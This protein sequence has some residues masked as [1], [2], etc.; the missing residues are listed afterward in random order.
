MTGLFDCERRSRINT[1]IR[2]TTV[3]DDTEDRVD[4]DPPSVSLTLGV[5]NVSGTV[6]AIKK[7]MSDLGGMMDQSTLSVQ[8]GD[9]SAFLSFRVDRDDFQ[10]ALKSIEGQG[11]VQLK[12]LQE[13]SEPPDGENRFPDEPNARIDVS[14]VEDTSSKTG[15]IVAIAAPSAVAFSVLLA[16]LFYLT[17]RAGG[18]RGVGNQ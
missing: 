10:F 11:S 5:S 4:S 6:D 9:D 1:I 16:A 17:Y 14:L 18:R 13:R 7:L 8:E 12:E 3:S 15:L 2:S